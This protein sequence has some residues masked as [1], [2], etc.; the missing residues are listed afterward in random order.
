[1]ILLVPRKKFS[2]KRRW[3]TAKITR[4]ERQANLVARQR[5][6]REFEG[7][8]AEIMNT[9][10]LDL[11]DV[12]ARQLTT[13]GV[14][15]VP[16]DSLTSL[17]LEFGAALSDTFVD[18]ITDGANIGQRFK[19]PSLDVKLN[20]SI[21]NDLSSAW[22]KT[23][24]A[25]RVTRVNQTVRR[26][27][28][29]ITAEAVQQTISPT[30]AAQRIGRQV[31]LSPRDAQAIRNFEATLMRRRIPTPEA[32]TQVVRET[33][34]RDVELFRDRKIRERGRLIAETEI[35]AAI[36]AGERM[37]WEQA[38]IQEQVDGGL[39]LK[40]WFTV[41]DPDVCPICRPLHGQ[42]VGFASSFSSLSFVGTDPPAHVR[43]RC[44]IEYAP[45]GDFS[46]SRAGG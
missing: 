1:M 38:I 5:L 15:G 46:A 17:E 8:F 21:I 16:Q 40:R 10:R 23:E 22:I 4:A 26:S 39:L 36:Q 34:A 41:Q 12:F 33:I 9:F 25:R 29:E 27:V 20:P 6:V 13:G 35:Q 19:P 24:G 45:N 28:R 43:C 11:D 18:G 37:Y 14:I 42:I 30:A 2:P 7:S 3:P 31:G 32:D 44:F